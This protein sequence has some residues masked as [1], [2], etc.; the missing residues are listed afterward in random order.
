MGKD[1]VALFDFLVARVA[2]FER[3]L[4]LDDTRPSL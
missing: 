4:R 2:G 1:E 3:R